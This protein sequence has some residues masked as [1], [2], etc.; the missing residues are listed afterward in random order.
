MPTP[1]NT[2][3]D[4]V[5]TTQ[6]TGGSPLPVLARIPYISRETSQLAPAEP[7][8][9]TITHFE[10]LLGEFGMNGAIDTDSL[11]PLSPADATTPNSPPQPPPSQISESS[12]PAPIPH[13]TFAASSPQ[14]AFEWSELLLRIDAAVEPYTRAIVMLVVVAVGA[15]TILLLRSPEKPRTPQSRPTPAITRH[16]LET[17]TAAP[18]VSSRDKTNSVA[19]ETLK[20][21]HNPNLI[22]S[23]PAGMQSESE[24][25]LARLSKEIRSAPSAQE[26]IDVEYPST[27][28]S[29][30]DVVRNAQLPASVEPNSTLK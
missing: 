21:A 20:E 8:N 3:N 30:P 10:Y 4:F 19:K 9:N 17:Q 28:L 15:F 2:F 27:A 12:F 13:Q 26:D 5:S 7:L 18:S 6:Q 16:L 22:A 1:T 25:P 23:G 29:P 14:R 24:P 11:T